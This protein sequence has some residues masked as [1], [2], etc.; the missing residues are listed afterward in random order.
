MPF[1]IIHSEGPFEVVSFEHF[2]LEQP[3]NMAAVIYPVWNAR[4]LF[5][6]MQLASS[7]D[8]ECRENDSIAVSQYAYSYYA[9][10]VYILWN[11]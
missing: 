9:L 2:S 11:V 8:S 4:T 10:K 6:H 5:S 1:K 3:F 7:C